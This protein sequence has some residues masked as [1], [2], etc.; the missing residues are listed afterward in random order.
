MERD[1]EIILDKI[2][3]LSLREDLSADKPIV[4]IIT[5]YYLV[6]NTIVRK[7]KEV[8]VSGVLPVARYYTI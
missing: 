6:S 3:Q 1:Y 7:Q 5:R 8:I 2:S 4:E